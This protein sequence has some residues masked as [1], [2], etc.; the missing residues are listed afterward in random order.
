MTLRAGYNYARAPIP[1]DQVMFNMLAPATSERHYTLG[2]TFLDKKEASDITVTYMY[3]PENII[4]GP[5]MFSGG[6][7]ALAMS[8][9]SVSI[10]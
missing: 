4:K 1:E 7:A 3:S 8:Q 5:T 6:S 2:A 10:A 9:Q